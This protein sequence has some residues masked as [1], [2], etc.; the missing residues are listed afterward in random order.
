MGNTTHTQRHGRIYRTL[1]SLTSLFLLSGN[2]L[3][4][5]RLRFLLIGVGNTFALLGLNLALLLHYP[6]YEE[7]LPVSP[8]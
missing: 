6:E 8:P 7:I 3:P 1:E 2:G 5:K 4:G